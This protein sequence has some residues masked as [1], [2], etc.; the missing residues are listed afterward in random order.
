VIDAFNHDMP[1]DVFVKAQIAA[2][3]LPVDAEERQKLLPGLGFFG[4][5]PWF[6][7]DDVV[8]VEARANERDDKI[9]SLTK[10]FLGLTVSCARCHDHKYDPISQKD[11]YS[12]AGIFAN[13][14]YWEYNLA[15]KDRVEAYRNHYK[16]IKSQE[17]AITDFMEEC[18][19]AAAGRL[20]RQTADYL[21]AARAAT[22][23]QGVSQPAQAAPGGLDSGTLERWMKYLGGKSREHPFLRDWDALAAKGGSDADAQRVADQFQKVVLDV[24]AEKRTIDAAN[25]DLR[26]HYRPD[27]NEA[28]AS[29]PGDLMQF[30]LF[31]FK[32]S[33]V[34]KVIDSGKF[35]L[36]LDIVQGPASPDYAPRVGIY[37][38]KDQDLLRYL[39]PD[40][41]K[42]LTSMQ[43]ELKRLHDTTPAEYP[44]LMGLADDPGPGNL[45]LAIRGNPHT[46]EKE[47]PRGWPAILAGMGDDPL[48]FTNGSG[49]LE[50]AEAVASHP[51]ATRVIVNRIWA[52]HFG[53]G[54]VAT[55]SNFGVMG[56]RPSHH[57]LLEYLASRLNENRGS[58]K[59]MHREIVL[60][61][62]YQLS[63]GSS[64]A[65]ERADPDNRLLWRANLRRLDAEALRDSLL[66]VTGTLDER[67]GGPP[68]NL[69]DANNKKRTVYGR[70]ARGGPNRLL[71][72]FD[73]P[74]PNLSSEQR[75]ITNVPLQGL[76]FLNSDLIWRQAG[77]LVQHINSEA[78]LN[79]EEENTRKIE[80]AY[81]LLFGRKATAS[82]LQR[83][84]RFIREAAQDSSGGQSAW[85]QYAQ[86][87]L[88]SGE[89]Y[90]VN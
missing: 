12:L 88:S 82:E 73:F 5:G 40:E 9:D 1:Y 53:R 27:P 51:L 63:Y 50:L 29:L 44:Y 30:E 25:R 70:V 47:V 43:K 10:G 67:V 14:G 42:Q 41:H 48:P 85:Q 21:M 37:E 36:W 71:V 18:Q 23:V 6:T 52:E 75:S 64:A 84:L 55:P 46:L 76:F 60:S 61:A 16:R 87:L 17:R 54:I 32:Q 49:R 57:D 2:D 3:L 24:I 13:S 66:F 39:T 72:L 74:D 4:L 65:I 31:Q 79:S 11:Y 68:Q 86:V 90:Y 20:A 58:L 81:S 33:L 89:F 22:S 35:A 34:Q 28:S 62:T 83:G 45:K 7:G 19:I 8:F 26:I 80:K 78:G 77:T 15:E 38:H 69:S 59:A 56:D